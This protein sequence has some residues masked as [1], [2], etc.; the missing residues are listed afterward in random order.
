D[1]GWSSSGRRSVV[2]SL[3][4]ARLVITPSSRWPTRLPTETVE[5]ALSLA[6]PRAG[7]HQAASAARATI[8]IVTYNGL[9][10]TKMCL[11]SLLNVWNSDDELII[12]DNASTDGTTDYLCQVAALNPFVRLRLNQCNRGFAAANNQAMASANGRIL[13][14]LNNDTIVRRNWAD[15]LIRW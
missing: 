1:I 14:L 5:A 8:I 6:P 7:C 2:P 4:P 13:I 15:D 3:L 9:A 10:Y 11:A 12:V